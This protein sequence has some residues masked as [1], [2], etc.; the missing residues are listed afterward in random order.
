[1]KDIIYDKPVGKAEM[2]ASLPPSVSFEIE[3]RLA[4]LLKFFN[5]KIVVLDDDPTG[6]QTVHGI[7]VYTD[8]EKAS[9]AQGFAEE[10]P[11]FFVL[12]NSR[13]LTAEQSR[14]THREIAENICWAACETGREFLIISRSDSTLRGHYPLETETL[15]QVLE[16]KGYKIDG[17]IIIPFFAEGERFTINNT[18]F[19]GM[20]DEL[21]PANLTEF[22][23]DLVFGYDNGNLRRWVE[24]K[25]GGRYPTHEVEAISLE[26]IRLNDLEGIKAKLMK[27]SG[28]SKTIVNAVD[29]YDIKVFTTALVLAVLSGKRFLLRS[30]AGLVRIIGGVGQKPYLSRDEL[31]DP[32][33]RAG[34]LVI[35]GSHVK[36][37][38]QQFEAIKDMVN[39]QFFELN[40]NLIFEPDRLKQEISRISREASACM[41]EGRNAVVYTSRDLLK[42]ATNEDN[43]DVSAKVS[44]ALVQIMRG[45]TTLPRYLVAKGGITS[46]DIGTKGLGVKKALV[47]GQILPGV[48]VWLTQSEAKFPGMPYIIFPGNVGG[49]DALR[50][51][52]ER[53]K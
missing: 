52:M 41:D 5:T 13:G 28:F 31:I 46:S 8:W 15:R 38:T 2:F 30:A 1:M 36:K 10:S 7:N 22:A 21:V 20:G 48:P 45:I 32:A 34:G 42:L 40:P 23:K 11:L 16:E 43:L 25:T 44:D 35:I 26:E 27:A 3:K 24:E 51:V 50:E 14:T 53:L 12:T 18:H 37:S 33:N 4:A 9:M 39:T 19:V 6:V 29:Y 17:E 47:A 49:P